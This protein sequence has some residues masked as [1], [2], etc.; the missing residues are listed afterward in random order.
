MY[1]ATLVDD[2]AE[3][4]GARLEGFDPVSRFFCRFRSG[5]TD[6]TVRNWVGSENPDLRMFQPLIVVVTPLARERI[7]NVFGGY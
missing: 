4:V 6:R 5:G 1:H 7:E 2:R 3:I